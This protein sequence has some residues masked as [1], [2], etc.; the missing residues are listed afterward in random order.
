[1]FEIVTLP[2][3]QKIQTYM[4]GYTIRIYLGDDAHS[5]SFTWGFVLQPLDYNHEPPVT[6]P[7]LIDITNQQ[8]TCNDVTT[9]VEI[10]QYAKGLAVELDKRYPPGMEVDL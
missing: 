6:S 10:L 8:V 4:N 1:M 5:R 7:A 9:F 3:G 2:S